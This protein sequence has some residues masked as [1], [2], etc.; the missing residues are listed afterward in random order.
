M[1]NN[2]ALLKKNILIVSIGFPL[3]YIGYSLL[4]WSHQLF[5]EH[6]HDYYF[7]FWG[8]MMALHWASFYAV[9]YMMKLEHRTPVDIGYRLSKKALIILISCFFLLGFILYGFTE[10]SLNYVSLDEDKLNQLPGLI[11]LTSAQRFFFL[12]L[13]FTAGFCEEYIY[14]AYLVSGLE[15]LGL[16]KWLALL[17]ATITFVFIHGVIGYYQFWFYFIPGLIFGIIY[18]ASKR[19]LPGLILHLLIDVLAIMGI[20]QA[21]VQ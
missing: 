15:K 13:A 9:K 19:L 2:L 1:E 7:H 18:V 3:I 5:S 14:R 12:F 20:F 10:W 17:P 4:P 16:N 21:V 11:P 6:N 8:G